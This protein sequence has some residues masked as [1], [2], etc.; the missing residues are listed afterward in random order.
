[1]HLLILTSI[2]QSLCLVVR[3]QD[4]TSAWPNDACT[5]KSLSI[6]SWIIKNLSVD[7]AQS[8]SLTVVNRVTNG[9]QQ[10]TCLLGHI[11]SP[12]GNLSVTTEKTGV[13]GQDVK[14]TIHDGW[15]CA[16]RNGIDDKPKRI[17]FKATGSDVLATQCEADRCVAEPKLIRGSI[18]EPFPITPYPDLATAWG[19]DRPNCHLPSGNGSWQMEARWPRTH[20]WTDLEL[21]LTHPGANFIV[22]CYPY[23]LMSRASDIPTLA[24]FSCGEDL[25]RYDAA[26]YPPEP[27]KVYLAGVYNSKTREVSFTQATWFCEELGSMKPFQIDASLSPVT[28]SDC[29]AA[30][31]GDETPCSSNI[32]PGTVTRRSPLPP[33]SLT[34]PPVMIGGCTVESMTVPYLTMSSFE[35]RNTTNAVT[36]VYRSYLEFWM[37]NTAAGGEYLWR[38]TIDL[39]YDP[40]SHVGDIWHAHGSWAGG[41][42]Q[43]KYDILRQKFT[44]SQQWLCNDKQQSKS[45]YFNATGS[46]ILTPLSCEDTSWSPSYKL[47]YLTSDGKRDSW[48]TQVLR[49]SEIWPGSSWN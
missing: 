11:C 10:L 9:E 12:Q 8:V 15:S 20:R 3:A 1:M 2:V 22:K 7:H 40:A 28:L 44:W 32:V 47:C 6:P 33:F 21:T 19:R 25:E 13:L 14:L 45:I 27:G 37:R 4:A 34:D 31:A 46:V 30:V 42:N 29:P 26:W 36:P 17:D 23:F 43:Y 5:D 18:L 35:L 24:D 49:P 41:I 16:D 38:D 48:K 39:S